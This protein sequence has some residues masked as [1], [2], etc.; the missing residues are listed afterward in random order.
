MC[1][2]CLLTVLEVIEEYEADITEHIENVCECC[3][4]FSTFLKIVNSEL[5]LLCM[6]KLK[7]QEQVCINNFLKISNFEEMVKDSI[8]KKLDEKME[9]LEQAELPSQ[10]YL[11]RVNNLHDIYKMKGKLEEA[12]HR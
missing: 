9:Q 10:E 2:N 6:T 3:R 5:K 8:K 7:K 4:E 1:K 11:S 12:D